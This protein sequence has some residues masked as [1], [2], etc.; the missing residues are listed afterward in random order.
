[1]ISLGVAIGLRDPD[2]FGLAAVLGIGL[3]LFRLQRLLGGAL[4]L[5][6]F[7]NISFWTVTAVASNLSHDEPVSSVILP[8]TLAVIALVGVVAALLSLALPPPPAR[9]ARVG[10]SALF[11]L[12]AGAATVVVVAVAPG[13]AATEDPLP[14][15]LVVRMKNSRFSVETLRAPAG[16]VSLFVANPDLFWH[17]VTISDLDVDVKVP[18]GAVRRTSFDAPPGRYQYVC[19]VPGHS[20][21]RGV[22]I[23]AP[24]SP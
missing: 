12:I 15:D 9:Q 18:V 1:V 24:P 2:A 22:L 6:L 21:M 20:R 14:G 10:R 23:V 5:L 11:G 3:L 16:K 4:L 7:G 17:T 19:R 13:L 8:T